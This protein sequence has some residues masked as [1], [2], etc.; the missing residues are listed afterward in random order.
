[1]VVRPGSA[2]RNEIVL[3]NWFTGT[4]AGILGTAVALISVSP[5]GR[6][7]RGPITGFGGRAANPRCALLQ[8]EPDRPAARQVT[9]AIELNGRE[10]IGVERATGDRHAL[11]GMH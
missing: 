8:L 1:M 11:P 5:S 9:V 7:R 4:R 10:I 6:A 3:K 2:R